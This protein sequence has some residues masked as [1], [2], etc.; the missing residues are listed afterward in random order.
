MNDINQQIIDLQSSIA[1]LE[2]TVDELNKIVSKQDKQLQDLQRQ[3]QLMFNFIDA[4]QS[5]GIAPFDL[6][7]D[8]PPHY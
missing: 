1:H 4:N 5:G 7:A 8:K 3:L 6:L 2:L